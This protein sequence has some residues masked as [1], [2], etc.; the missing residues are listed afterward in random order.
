MGRSGLRAA[1]VVLG[2][3]TALIHVSLNVPF[4]PAL[5]IFTLNGLGYLALVA[6]FAFD[7]PLVRRQRALLHYAFIGYA[8]VTILAWVAIGQRDIVGF[9]DKA[10]EIGLVIALWRHLRVGPGERDLIGASSPGTR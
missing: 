5:A 9:V 1:I 2:T 3:A 4:A 8:V 7:P 10:I 6:A